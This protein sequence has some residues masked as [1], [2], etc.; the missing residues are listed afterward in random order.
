MAKYQLLMSYLNN[1][2]VYLVLRASE[3]EARGGVPVRD[4]PV[5]ASLV[6]F[7]RRIEMMEALETRLA[8]VLRL[9]A[10]ELASGAVDDT[11]EPVQA[12]ASPSSDSEMSEPLPK[13][14]KSAQKKKQKKQQVFLEA[15]P[16]TD[17]YA[18]LQAMLKR[19]KKKQKK[20]KPVEEDYG[21]M[22]H[23]EE[24]DAEDKARAIRRLRHHA[25]R[26][27][28][29]H[30]KRSNKSTL[31]GD[32]DLPYREKKRL[33]KLRYDD[34]SAAAARAQADEF[35]SDLEEDLGE[36]PEDDYYQAVQRQQQAKK[37]AKKQ[38]KEQALQAKVQMMVE[39]NRAE[40]QD[41]EMDQKRNV[42]YQ[43]L[44]NKGMMPR[45]TKEQ[46][47]PR[48]KRRMR[49]EQAKK[50]LKSSVAQVR[51]Q[52]GSYGGEATGIKSNLSR[53]TRLG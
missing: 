2:A 19:E 23:L 26:V 8:P 28:Q 13:P 33:E 22:E 46:R 43:I 15:A 27:A 14:K 7:R 51:K 17:S 6:E 44:K 18:E 10:N 52:E 5:I 21:E 40:E 50:K 31:S 12:A 38:A 39:A 24:G 3:S 49:F 16:I 42:N 29:A 34:A 4:H 20:Q 11:E 48:V 36:A 25:K 45:R 35:G 32:M 53:S 30:T 9:F 47:N 37:Q 1:V 41:V